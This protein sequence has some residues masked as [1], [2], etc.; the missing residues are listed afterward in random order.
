MGILELIKGFNEH[1]SDRIICKEEALDLFSEEII[2]L[3]VECGIIVF[4]PE[5]NYYTMV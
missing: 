5:N 1:S 2:S 3:A 4:I